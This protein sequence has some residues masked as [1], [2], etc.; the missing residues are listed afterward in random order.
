[1]V[2]AGV[3]DCRH[4]NFHADH[5]RYASDR[6]RDKSGIPATGDGVR[7][8]AR[9]PM[10]HSNPAIFPRRILYGLSVTRKKIRH[11]DEISGGEHFR[12]DARA[13]GG[14]AIRGHRESG[15]HR[16]GDG[17][18]RVGGGDHAADS[19]LH[20]SGRD[21][22][23]HLDGRDA[24]LLIYRRLRCGVFSAA[25]QNS[26]RMLTTFP[27]AAKRTPSASARV[28]TKMLAAADFVRVPNLLSSN[29]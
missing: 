24:I 15:E 27:M 21:A 26:S 5:H 20:I 25:A 14:R 6:V 13:G 1:M 19:V 23:R 17:R 10:H 4:G 12:G 9:H 8:G 11:A 22:R 28:T 7:G 2:G 18:S 29:W 16:A 3:L